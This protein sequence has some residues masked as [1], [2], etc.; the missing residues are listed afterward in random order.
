MF[1]E[2]WRWLEVVAKEAWWILFHL[3]TN[4]L[5][6]EWEKKKKAWCINSFFNFKKKKLKKS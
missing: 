3:Q 1:K 4:T 6:H 2:K 5:D